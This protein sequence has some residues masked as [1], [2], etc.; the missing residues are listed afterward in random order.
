MFANRCDGF[1]DLQRRCA[2][3][4]SALSR[5][6]VDQAIGERVAKR[7]AQLQHV[8]AGPGES[9]SEFASCLEVGIAGADI[10]DKSLPSLTS[11]P[12]EAVDNAVHAGGVSGLTR[13]DSSGFMVCCPHQAKAFEGQKWIDRGDFEQ[14]SGDEMAV[15]A[16]SDHGQSFG[17]QFAFQFSYQLAD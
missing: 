17:F 12:R 9:Q 1:Q 16:G 11:Q 13:G 2:R 14:A 7:N 6:L 15:A 3:F 8:H 5:Q 4:E 10:Y